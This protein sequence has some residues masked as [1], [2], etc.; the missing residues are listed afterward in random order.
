MKAGIVLQTQIDD[1]S[2]NSNGCQIFGE[3]TV[4]TGQFDPELRDL[5]PQKACTLFASFHPTDTQSG[6]AGT[7][8]VQLNH[9]GIFVFKMSILKKM[10]SRIK[11]QRPPEDILAIAKII[12][13]LID[14]TANQIFA[15]HKLTLLKAP[16]TYIVPA[17]WG[18]QKGGEPDATQMEINRQVEPVVTQIFEAL[19]TNDIDATQKFAIGFLIRGLFISKIAYMIEVLK[20]RTIEQ[21][22]KTNPNILNGIEPLGNA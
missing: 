14:D 6:Q 12:G 8:Q 2:Q 22:I 10:F 5:C 21:N 7:K 4:S 9:M 20:N 1:E 17:V 13:P 11:K 19:A 15:R 18:A 16:V 3:K